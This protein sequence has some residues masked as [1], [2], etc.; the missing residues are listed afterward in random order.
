MCL[1]PKTLVELRIGLLGRCRVAAVN[2]R[3]WLIFAYGLSVA[4]VNAGQRLPQPV[5]FGSVLVSLRVTSLLAK[6]AT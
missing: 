5:R 3:H 4:N 2:A 6:P 1:P